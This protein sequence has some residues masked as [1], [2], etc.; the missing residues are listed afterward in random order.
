MSSPGLVFVVGRFQPLHAGHLH[1]LRQAGA[2]GRRVVVLSYAR[3]EAPG[4]EAAQRRTWLAACRAE[5]AGLHDVVVRSGE[6]VPADDAPA[7]VHRDYC[8][9]VIEEAGWTIDA[10]ASSEAY[11][12]GLARHLS[13]RLGREITHLAVDPER[14][15]VP[16]SGT[17]VRADPERFRWA[18]PPFVRSTYPPPPP[19][20]VLPGLGLDRADL[21]DAFLGRA[22]EVSDIV[23][24]LL[25]VGIQPGDRVL[26]AGC[27][28]GRLLRPLQA[29]GVWPEGLDTDEDYVR[30]ARSTGLPVRLGSFD[31]VREDTLYD[32]VLMAN[33]PVVYLPDRAQRRA[34]LRAL[35][36]GLRPGGTLVVDA[37]NLPWIWSNI[38][39]VPSPVR[40]T[41]GR[42]TVDR[43]PA[44]DID[45]VAG[46]WVHTDHHRLTDPDG[47][48]AT[49]TETFRFRMVSRH[50]LEADLQSV[51]CH[52][53][54]WWSGWRATAPGGPDG[55]RLLVTCSTEPLR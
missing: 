37:P 53:I 32:A 38:Y 22:D 55:P 9:D 50:D 34:A 11:G 46:S 45:P 12:P 48:A 16:M 8:A 33:G 41:I 25:R 19:S 27:G 47:R 36:T 31:T 23:D 3:P 1:V 24:F 20:K 44:H 2:H 5:V 30:R 52:G 10:V 40:R 54:V 7:E 17:R 35:C 13:R 51:G 28:T 4:C 21:Y 39:R 26:D 18:L 14:S 49:C 42:F 43:F 29:A 6:T 15:T